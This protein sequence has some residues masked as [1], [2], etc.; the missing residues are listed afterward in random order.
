MLV[1]QIKMYQR[2]VIVVLKNPFYSKSLTRILMWDRGKKK[3]MMKNIK[4][5][6]YL[7]SMKAQKMNTS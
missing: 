3:I 5:S 6:N 4:N 1:V 2:A 7:H